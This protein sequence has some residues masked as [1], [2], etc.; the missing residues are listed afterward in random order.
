MTR[1][2]I[3]AV[4]ALSLLPSVALAVSA[5]LSKSSES[6]L[7]YTLRATDTKPTSI[8][9]M[10][11]AASCSV[12]AQLAS[13][14]V[15]VVPR[16]DA[17]V[18]HSTGTAGTVTL[19]AS[20]SGTLTTSAGQFSVSFTAVSNSTVT[21]TCAPGGGGAAYDD[22]AIQASIDTLE[23]SS[24][25]VFN[26]TE[27]GAIAG[28]GLSDVAAIQSAVDA[29]CAATGDRT[30]YL[31]AGDYE[32]GDDTE[33][34]FYNGSSVVIDTDTGCHGLT[35]KGAGREVT[36]LLAESSNG[37]AMIT[38]CNF[39]T[40][41]CDDTGDKTPVRDIR[42]ADLS[43][44]D[45]DPALHGS[46]NSGY[47]FADAPTLGT[48][49]FGDPVAWA[50]GSGV[51]HSYDAARGLYVIEQPTNAPSGTLIGDGG[52]WIGTNITASVG[53]RVEGTHGLAT[54]YVD[55]MTIERVGCFNISDECMDLKVH[56]NNVI[57]KDIL[58]V[59]VGQIGEGGSTVSVANSENVLIDG[60]SIN[61]G[62]ASNGASASGINIA[63][64]DPDRDP[65]KN[66]RIINGTIFDDSVD[67]ADKIEEGFALNVSPPANG[68][69]TLMD[70]VVISNVVVE[71]T[72]GGAFTAAGISANTFGY[73]KISD[74]TFYG[75][76]S[77]ASAFRISAVNVD[78]FDN[79]GTGVQQ[80]FSSLTNVY[81]DATSAGTDAMIINHPFTMIGSTLVG[82]T[83]DGIAL[84]GPGPHVIT[85]N[86]F[87]DI[88]LND[89]SASGGDIAVV[90]EGTATDIVLTNNIKKGGN[91]NAKFRVAKA[92]SNDS[93]CSD[94][95]L[96]TG[97]V[98]LCSNN[99]ILP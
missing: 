82:S 28:D 87:I 86:S 13:G 53:E 38:F 36:R 71:M 3:A 12:T 10:G 7:N 43:F 80:G 78:F 19:S 79:D 88:G 67:A 5:N 52:A 93:S 29:A 46:Q 81:F 77:T 42:I 26:V 20:G 92:G 33:T 39:G 74:S 14:S 8:L 24:I 91:T 83:A 6:T 96:V 58:S 15:S 68:V 94:D 50:G 37:Q 95:T 16:A 34:Q 65:T 31:P 48:P 99:L 60:F 44:V 62:T 90:A 45:L 73:V 27:F 72:G 57:I 76:V 61:G 54:K 51:F 32:M 35:I 59:G 9:S 85:G 23:A 98:G 41:N 1:T 17:S 49:V 40:S 18:A 47:A 21:V 66:I 4:A 25:P 70:N 56:S 22:T 75:A 30:V 64:G 89:G 63:T 69:D 11:G 84:T 55:G 2:I 97:L